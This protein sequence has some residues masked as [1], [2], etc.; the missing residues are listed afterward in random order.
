MGQCPKFNATIARNSALRLLIMTGGR[1]LFPAQVNFIPRYLVSFS[2]LSRSFENLTAKSWRKC[3]CLSFSSSVIPSAIVRR[4]FMIAGRWPMA[5]DH[6]ITTALLGFEM[7]IWLC[8]LWYWLRRRDRQTK[9]VAANSKTNVTASN[10]EKDAVGVCSIATR[11][12][13]IATNLVHILVALNIHSESAYKTISACLCLER[14]YPLCSRHCVKS[15]LKYVEI[16][17]PRGTQV[18]VDPPR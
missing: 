12:L 4:D 14:S 16:S 15:S 6:G 17:V 18:T 10:A 1:F 9:Y 11:N 8:Q 5:Q 3:P 13:S 2:S 7:H